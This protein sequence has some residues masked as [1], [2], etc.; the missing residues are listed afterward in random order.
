MLQGRHPR[1]GRRNTTS[2]IFICVL[3]LLL[4]SP[5]VL[6][7]QT[8]N[9]QVIHNAADP[10]LIGIDVYFN[11]LRPA[12]ANDLLFRNA[13]P[14]FEVESGETDIGVSKNA[15]FNASDTLKN[16]RVTLEADQ[17]Y[18]VF[19][20]GVLDM[21]MVP[22]PEGEDI[23]LRIVVKEQ[24]R[25]V[26]N[27]PG[28]IDLLLMHGVTDSPTIELRELTG[29]VAV[30]P[31]VAYG[32]VSN[33]VTTT[34]ASFDLG[35]TWT[36][37]SSVLL[38]AYRFELS[39]YSGQAVTLV[40]SGFRAPEKNCG[41][42][43][44]CTGQA[45]LLIT[46]DGG[47]VTLEPT[48]PGPFVAG[49]QFIHA[50]ADR[51]IRRIDLYI[52]GQKLYDDLSVNGALPFLGVF[53]GRSIELGIGAEASASAR[54]A[55]KSFTLS[56]EAG[57]NYTAALVGLLSPFIFAP[58]PDG[59]DTGLQLTI[60]SGARRALQSQTTAE[61]RVLHAL[62]DVGTLDVKDHN[63]NQFLGGLDFGEIS[64]YETT[65]TSTLPVQLS[66]QLAPAYIIGRFSVPFGSFGQPVTLIATGFEEKFKNRLG[67]VVKLHAVYADGFVREITADKATA[68]TARVQFIHAAPDPD[69]SQVDL[70]IQDELLYDNLS[71]FRAG[72]Y[73]TT[74]ADSLID[75]GIAPPQSTSSD[76]V[77][78]TLPIE[79]DP[80]ETHSAVL[81]GVATPEIFKP[82]PD[83]I[84]T[85]LTLIIAP[86]AH[87]NSTAPPNTQLRVV[88]AV[89]DAPT[90][91]IIIDQI[92]VLADSAT[93]GT[94]TDY[95]SL[96]PDGSSYPDDTGYH[97]VFQP[98]GERALA[99]SFLDLHT[100]GQR[101]VTVVSTG[102]LDAQGNNNAT[103]LSSMLV[104]PD[105]F[106]PNVTETIIVD[107]ED[108]L[109]TEVS[110]FRIVGTYPNPAS[111]R[112]SL[113]LDIP[114]AAR[115]HIALYDV[116]GRRLM[117]KRDEIALPG[118][119]RKFELDLERLPA[120]IYT[121]RVTADSGGKTVVAQSQ[122]VRIR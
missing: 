10:E 52:D 1:S 56:L 69:V 60:A 13:T 32:E 113:L 9:V 19:I 17:N 105:G 67:P 80:F 15:S 78:Y 90:A 65:G 74:L 6:R 31:P 35:L 7:A 46:P 106:V 88:Y 20:T 120:G 94:T 100:V 47:E 34:P 107:T 29:D 4:I 79:L 51:D 30:V 58:N 3:G 89:P 42:S 39:R 70:Y 93:F 25:R 54:D 41:A 23:G 38:E 40:F 92:E 108:D 21:D 14:F 22:N 99:R 95:V 75:I 111:N 102:F 11:G 71:F 49:L 104:Y 45:L 61:F 77:V 83:G 55:L 28:F 96:L 85:D 33:Y 5:S 119:S 91:D 63:G 121:V 8:A 44:S 97:L 2:G 16:T 64:A 122:L 48:D 117:Q 62:T 72:S 87:E 68:E 59:L 82:N 24:A 98:A 12:Q 57:E 86:G 73:I 101:A 36:S 27:A 76:E 50:S 81:A 110:G 37:L 66:P 43:S 103:A 116:T 26:A 18:L 84:P 118:A 112:T 115:L 114:Q 53:S 109:P